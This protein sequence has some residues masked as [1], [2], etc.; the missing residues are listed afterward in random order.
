M[1]PSYRSIRDIEKELRPPKD[2]Q[3]GDVRPWEALLR[4]MASIPPHPRVGVVQLV[5]AWVNAPWHKVH[6]RR[7]RWE[8]KRKALRELRDYQKACGLPF[9]EPGKLD[10]EEERLLRYNEA[11]RIGK[12]PELPDLTRE[13]GFGNIDIRP[14][15]EAA[16][17]RKF[18]PPPP[19]HLDDIRWENPPT[20]A[21][22]KL[23][24]IDWLT[25]AGTGRPTFEEVS[26]HWWTDRNATA[27]TLMDLLKQFSGTYHHKDLAEVLSVFTP[28]CVSEADLKNLSD[29]YCMKIPRAV[30]RL[31]PLPLFFGKPRRQKRKI[32]PPG[33]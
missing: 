6:W 11:S 20:Q 25:P 21:V 5:Q 12:R 13:W 14:E 16:M 10:E 27:V 2:A 18:P 22:G 26:R 8:W 7:A 15:L 33:F 1:P 30:D 4:I 9:W 3:P 23:A 32:D 17:E 29:R 28:K 19:I 24:D 31:L